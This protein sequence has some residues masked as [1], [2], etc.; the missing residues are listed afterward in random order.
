MAAETREGETRV[1]VVPELVSKLTGL[2][3]T[4]AVEPGAGAGALHPDDEYIAAGAEVVDEPWL[5]ADLVVS[6]NPLTPSVVRL[7]SGRPPRWSASAR[8]GRA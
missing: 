4:V 1:A 6:V 3:Y 7:R 5:D 2:G 8:P